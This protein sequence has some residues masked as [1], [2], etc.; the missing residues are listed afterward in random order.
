MSED[1]TK[2]IQIDLSEKSEDLQHWVHVSL[3]TLESLSVNLS[4]MPTVRLPLAVNLMEV[5]AW[6]VELNENLF[7]L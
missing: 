4:K 1:F 3:L 5:E 2:K 6:G 7:G